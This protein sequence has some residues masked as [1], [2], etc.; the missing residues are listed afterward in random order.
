MER[1]PPTPPA[2]R[3]VG[4]ALLSR[5]ARAWTGR[6]KMLVFEGAY[7]GANDIGV[8]SLFPAHPPDFPERCAD[9]RNR[10]QGP[11]AEHAVEAILLE[12]QFLRRDADDLDGVSEAPLE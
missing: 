2:P 9:V 6:S 3:P 12:R 10:A 5:L 11:G 4:G 1:L 8:T 7:H